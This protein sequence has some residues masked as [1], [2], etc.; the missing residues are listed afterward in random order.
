MEEVR[1]FAE[2]VIDNV[3]RVIVG[4]RAAVEMMM[5]ALLCNG[6]VL[7]EDVPAPLPSAWVAL[8]SGC[9]ARPISCPTM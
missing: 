8:S 6:H 1:A 9:S 7:I 4:K 2:A 3:G 5:V